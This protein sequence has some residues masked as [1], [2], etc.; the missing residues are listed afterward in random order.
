MEK[1]IMFFGMVAKD[2]PLNAGA[3]SMLL[4]DVGV[5]DDLVVYF[6]SEGGYVTEGMAI[7]NL[8][9]N[10]V[11]KSKTAVILGACQSI[12]TVITLA[13]DKVYISPL[14][15][16]MLHKVWAKVEGNADSLREAADN[17][18]KLDEMLF[19]AYAKKTGKSI[20]DIKKYFEK[21][22]YLTPDQAVSEGFC[23]G[24]YEMPEAMQQATNVE[25][26][27][28]EEKLNLFSNVFQMAKKEPENNTTLMFKPEDFKQSLVTLGVMTTYEFDAYEALYAKDVAKAKNYLDEKQ[29]AFK[30]K[31][32]GLDTTTA[33]TGESVTGQPLMTAEEWAKQADLK[34]TTLSSAFA[35]NQNGN[36]KPKAN[37]TYQDWLDKDPEG[38]SIM[39]E[40]EPDKVE[41]LA[42]AHAEANSPFKKPLW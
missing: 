33:K 23:D 35:Q 7:Y 24:L 5:D 41:S 39:L 26:M 17:F 6:H 22:T 12:A 29:N 27:T 9:K 19:T 3:I 28:F 8:F 34:K 40:N 36:E 38:L 11:A 25:K 31:L 37:W 14:A 10:A 42:K 30:S 4:A 13:F 18:D 2:R 16:Y 20:D 32:Q 1:T 21:D 15:N